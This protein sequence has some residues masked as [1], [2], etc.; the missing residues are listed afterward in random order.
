MRAHPVLIPAILILGLGAVPAAGQGASV[1]PPVSGPDIDGCAQEADLIL[2][3]ESCTRIIKGEAG[4]VAATIAGPD[5]STMNIAWAFINR[6]LAYE[7]IGRPERALG[8]YNTAVLL[9]PTNAVGFNNRGNLLAQEMNDLEGALADHTRAIEI[10]PGYAQAF[11]N[12]GLDNEELGRIDAAIV[13]FGRALEADPT[14]L[15]P[16]VSRSGLLCRVGRAGESLADHLLLL[17][18]GHFRPEQLQEYL[19]GK[20]FYTARV[21]GIF[22]RGS[23]A[24]LRAWIEAK[25]P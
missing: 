12:R 8:D 14:D 19:A 7:R 13:D 5:D 1:A 16:L 10:D 11:F 9:D 22:G 2:R 25:C 23:Q 4:D 17:E 3:I 24:A 21:D 6:A 15:R 20:G 18:R